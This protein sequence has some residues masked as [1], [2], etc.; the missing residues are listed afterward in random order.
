MFR[1]LINWDDDIIRL[2]EDI[3]F[4]EEFLY[5]QKYRFEDEFEYSVMVDESANTCL[6]PKLIIQPLVENACIH[7]VESIS[8]NRK[9]VIRIAVMDRQ[10]LISVSDNGKGIDEPRLLKLKKMLEGGEKLVHSVGLY[11]VYQRLNLYYEK[12]FTMDIQSQEGQGTK[13]SIGIPVR[14]SKEEF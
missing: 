12:N 10:I 2:S 13:V 7:G 8:Q 4:L 11:N 5:V 14:H 9:I 1:H 3:K 6:L